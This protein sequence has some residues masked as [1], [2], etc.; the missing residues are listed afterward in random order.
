M[1][2]RR[3]SALVLLLALVAGGFGLPVADAV[4]YHSTPVSTPAPATDDISIGT[5]AS[6]M[7]FQGCVLWLSALAGSGLTG[8]APALSV[9]ADATSSVRVFPPQPV[10]LQSHLALR[11]SRAPPIA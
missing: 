7:H 2:S 10:V 11:Q 4:F 9:G 3:R 5:P 6:S 1:I 8:Q